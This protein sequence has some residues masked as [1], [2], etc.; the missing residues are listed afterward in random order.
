M[1]R[2]INRMPGPEEVLSFEMPPITLNG[3]QAAPDQF[4]VRR[5]DCAAPPAWR[6]APALAHSLFPRAR[7]TWLTAGPLHSVRLRV[8]DIV[9]DEV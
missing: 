6:I 4:S 7:R 1:S 2:I 9:I 5:E 8:G 3:E